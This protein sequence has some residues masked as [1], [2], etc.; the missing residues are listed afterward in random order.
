MITNN[1]KVNILY[2]II[3]PFMFL[4]SSSASMAGDLPAGDIEFVRMLL[5]QPDIDFTQFRGD[6]LC[7]TLMYIIDN[8][9]TSQRDRIVRRA[10]C[11]LPETGDERAVE[12]LIEYIP[13]YPLDCL[14]GLGKFSTV[15]SCDTLLYYIGNEDRFVRRFSIQSL[16]RLD[17]TASE[18]MWA[19]RDLVLTSLSNR[20]EVETEDWIFPVIEAS[21]TASSEQVFDVKISDPDD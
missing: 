8:D 18:D 7:D 13:D 14:D 17:F 4:F 11:A 1:R 5:L 20:M 12:Y 15:E 6:E 2:F 21:F 9:Q 3:I 10:L 19:K 16:G